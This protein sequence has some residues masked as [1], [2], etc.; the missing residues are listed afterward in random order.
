MQLA[1]ALVL[2]FICDY[3][4][5]R[6]MWHILPHKCD[7]LYAMLIHAL[8]AEAPAAIALAVGTGNIGCVMCILLVPMHML[9]DHIG[10]RSKGTIAKC[11]DQAAHITLLLIAYLVR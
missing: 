10:G 9:I 2:H 1:I 8:Y 4:V 6:L 7:S 5:Q 3:Y 11:I